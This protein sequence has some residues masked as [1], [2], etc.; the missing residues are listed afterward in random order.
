[1]T[2]FL[3][4]AATTD[5]ASL[6]TFF[7]LD[8]QRDD[9]LPEGVERDQWGRP[10]IIQP[11]GSTVAYTRASTLA[12]YLENKSGLHTWDTRRIALGVGLDE[13]IAAMAASVQPFTGDKRKDRP[14]NETLDEVIERARTVAK[15]HEGRDWGTAV[16]GFTE[17]GQEGNP[18]VPERMQPDVDSYWEKMRDYNLSCQA[19]E[20]FVVCDELKVAGTFDDLYY[21]YLHGLVVADKKTGRSKIHSHAIQIAVYSRSKVYDIDTG[22]RRPLQSLVEERY[23]SRAINQKWGYYVHIA[24]GEGRTSFNFLDLEIGWEAAKVAAA[25]RDFQQTRSGIVFDGHEELARAARTELAW[26]SIENAGSLEE[27]R[28]IAAD[29]RDVWT[30]RMTGRGQARIASGFSDEG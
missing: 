23:A 15:E 28:A 4:E 30:D 16:H 24:K 3:A 21:G 18:W 19:S 27:L 2:R 22:E 13:D 26:F 20:V 14:T 9:G 25:A 6:D 10:K 1:M 7:E 5:Q 8:H 11:D 12:G 17:P 29:Y